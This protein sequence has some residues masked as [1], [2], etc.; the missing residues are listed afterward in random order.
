MRKRIFL[1][2]VTVCFG[3]VVCN[4]SFGAITPLL[5]FQGHL[6]DSEGNALTGTY[7]I[8]FSIYDVST[9]GTALWVEIHTSV[10]V[11][12]GLFSVV[13]GSINSLNLT[14]NK[15]YWLGIKVGSDTE[16]TPRQRITSA[17]YAIRATTSTYAITAGTAAYSQSVDW[18]N[19]NNIPSGFAD[20]VDDTGGTL[21]SN[22]IGTYH[23]INSTITTED[24]KDGTITD[25]DISSAANISVAKL[26]ST[27]MVEGENISLL[28]N[29]AGYVTA[30]NTVTYAVNAGTASYANNV[31]DNSIT[32]EKIATDAVKDGE[33]DY[34]QVTLSDFTNDAGFITSAD[35]TVT[36]SEIEGIAGSGNYHVA[37][38]THNHDGI[39]QPADADLYDL[40]DGELSASKVQYGSY[41]IT[42]PGTAGQVWKS[43]GLG[44]GYWG[45]DN[46]SGGD[47]TAVSAGTGLSGGGTS[48]DVTLAISNATSAG[49]TYTSIGNSADTDGYP[50][51]A[52]NCDTVD[53][54]HA[55]DFM[56]AGTDNWVDTTGDTMTGSLTVNGVIQTS[57][58]N[59]IKSDDDVYVDDCLY[60]SDRIIN[61]DG[62]VWIDDNLNVSGNLSATV[63]SGYAIYGDGPYGVYG[64]SDDEGGRGVYG[65]ASYSGSSY[66]VYGKGGC[67]LY[68]D[69]TVNYG[70]YAIGNQG[71][72]VESKS[73]TFYALYV[74]SYGGS[75]SEPG[76]YVY[77]KA[78]ITGDLNVTG[79]KNFLIDHPL[80]PHN[81][82][83]RHTVVESP[84]RKNIYDGI[85]TLNSNGEA[86]V[87]L[88][89]YFEALNKNYRYQLT[90]IGKYAPLYIKEEIKDSK[91]VIASANGS[92]D[93][94]VKISWQVTGIR[95]DAY[96]R[97]NPIIV[98]EEK[99]INNRFKKG[100][101]IH[102]ECFE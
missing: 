35:D 2:V 64:Y 61:N 3:L 48:G 97:K 83:L 67:G 23:I 70:I 22:S 29:D 88:P 9:G 39:Y 46:D 66:G 16:M 92:V 95:N 41:F 94:G 73:G 55:S 69:G 80:D 62:D 68:G 63:S 91:F 33:I 12:D 57:G 11:D 26:E 45:T 86:T 101:Y 76:L 49:K 5:N 75:S 53:G 84:E 20:G 32:S 78:D 7:S 37:Y 79:S 47:I 21:G 38:G 52:D 98:E 100:E 54:Y 1:M 4:V 82:I 28:N 43:D 71:N 10:S 89:D 72:K 18:T 58:G 87:E 19:I 17:G 85:V 30:S 50:D 99:G 34:S 36:W 65:Y 31:A 74:K 93:A 6:T 27:V 81:K 77:G 15:D 96:A 102:P 42:S 40:A 60:V 25:T 59:D 51:Y 13:L 14:F 90:P 24:I 8:T 56:P 44:A